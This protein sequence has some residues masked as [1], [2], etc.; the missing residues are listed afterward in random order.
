MLEII[1]LTIFIATIVNLVLTRFHIPTIIGYIAT[2]AIITYFFQLSSATHSKELETIAEFGIVFLMFTIGLEFSI[3]HLME[4]RKEVFLYGGLQVGLSMFIFYLIGFY[5]FEMLAK[6][7]IIVAAALSLS[8]TAIVL[9]ILNSNRDI[10]KEY[11][12]RSLGILIFQ[13]IMVVPI[14]LMISIFSTDGVSLGSLLFSTLVDAVV[15]FLL[16]WG[17]GKYILDPFLSE[18]VKSNLDEIFI[19]S[20]LFLVVG[21]SILAHNLGFS[22]SLGAFIAGM[23]ISETHYKHQVEADLIPFRDLLLGVFFI[24]VGMQIDFSIVV[25]KFGMILSLLL[26]FTI[27]KIS[28]IFLLLYKKAGKRVALKTSL[29]LFQLGEFGLVIFELANSSN[30][31]E[32][33]I[34]QILTATIILSMILT[35][36]VLRKISSVVDMI[37]GDELPTDGQ[38]VKQSRLKDHIIVLGYGRLGR[39]ICSKLD[40]YGAKYIAI[41]SNYH[42]VKEAQKEGKS[43]IFGNA[44]KRSILESVNIHQAAS[45]IIAME[46]SERLHLIGDILLKIAPTARVIIKVNKFQER[47]LLQVEFPNYEIVVG[48]EQMAQ[49]MVDAMMQCSISHIYTD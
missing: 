5:H 24:S 47:E 23:I 42:N 1:V 14:L 43:V 26:L 20:I 37:L 18:V 38:L 25:D 46:N 29:A 17:F 34:S 45:V 33:T 41:E 40:S 7:S 10:D 27:V 22:Y 19:G 32:P 4:M 11:G 6:E 8:S 49:G 48:V 2:G 36:F 21:S 30:L 44:G 31:I 3:R 13:D 15:L 39:K 12:K 35:P 16:L 28:I 9:K